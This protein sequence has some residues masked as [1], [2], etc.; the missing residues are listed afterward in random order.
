MNTLLVG[1]DLNRTGQN[2]DDLIN[3]LK[4]DYDNWW[5]HLDS[6]WIIKTSFSAEEVRNQLWQHMDAN[7]EML[8]VD[9]TGDAAA[10]QGFND[11]GSS[12]LRDNL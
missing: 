1:Y 5:H 7:D 12:W 9:I 6:T 2:Y 4:E 10:W 8:V 11:R 3:A